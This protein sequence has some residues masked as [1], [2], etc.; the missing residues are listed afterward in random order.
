MRTTENTRNRVLFNCHLMGLI[1]LTSRQPIDASSNMFESMNSC[2]VLPDFPAWDKPG[3]DI[4]VVLRKVLC[5]LHAHICE[6]EH[7]PIHWVQ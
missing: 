3:L 6:E 7:R 1:K 4:W 2:H 5:F